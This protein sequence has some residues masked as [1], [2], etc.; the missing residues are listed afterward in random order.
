MRPARLSH[1]LAQARAADAHLG[2]ILQNAPNDA[3]ALLAHVRAA[4]ARLGDL[5]RD[6]ARA[7]IG[8]PSSPFSFASYLKGAA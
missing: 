8:R 7:D 2:T 3:D 1:L 4:H 5:L 6:A